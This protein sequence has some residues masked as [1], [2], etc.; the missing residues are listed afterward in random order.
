MRVNVMQPEDAERLWPVIS[1]ILWPAVRQDP[2]YDMQT[3]YEMVMSGSAFLLEVEDGAHGLWVVSVNDDIAWTTAIA[4]RIDG[5]PKQRLNTI[6]TAVQ[7]IEAVGKA[8]GWKA[9]RICGRDWSTI[10]PDYTPYA[11]ERNGI[12]KVLA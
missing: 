12:E 10:L 5:G 3:L 8:R 4:G 2:A 11:G 9:H 1:D 7:A 6:R